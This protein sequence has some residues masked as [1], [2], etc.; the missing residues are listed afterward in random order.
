MRTDKEGPG[1]GEAAGERARVSDWILPDGAGIRSIWTDCIDAPG[2][3]AG[4]WGHEGGRWG[5]GEWACSTP[6]QGFPLPLGLQCWVFQLSSRHLLVQGSGSALGSGQAEGSG[7]TDRSDFSTALRVHGAWVGRA[8]ALS[9]LLLPTLELL[10]SATEQNDRV[11]LH[12]HFARKS[13]HS[14]C[15]VSEALCSGL[16]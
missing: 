12:K 2:R 8:A 14:S 4:H 6:L 7:P 3:A 1:V 15:V 13:L 16:F 11:H 10:F 9:F 5:G